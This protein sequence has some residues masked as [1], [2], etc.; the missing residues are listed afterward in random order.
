MILASSIIAAKIRNLSITAFAYWCYFDRTCFSDNRNPASVYDIPL[1]NLEHLQ[2]D[3]TLQRHIDVFGSSV[4]MDSIQ[5]QCL[6]RLINAR[7]TF[8]LEIQIQVQEY[9]PLNTPEPR[10]TTVFA[11]S[12]TF[13][14][15]LVSK[16]ATDDEM[17]EACKNGICNVLGLNRPAPKPCPA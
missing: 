5:T 4:T 16:Y 14:T 13:K 10:I 7:K 8:D 11:A 15:G 1:P 6:V 9:T 2:L 12:H 3:W 17:M